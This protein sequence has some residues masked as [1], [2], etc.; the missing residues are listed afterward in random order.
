[1]SSGS[2]SNGHLLQTK[3][4]SDKI[5]TLEGHADMKTFDTMMGLKVSGCSRNLHD[6]EQVR[7]QGLRRSRVLQLSSRL[8]IP[9]PSSPER[10]SKP[11]LTRSPEQRSRLLRKSQTRPQRSLKRCRRLLD[12][13]SDPVLELLSRK[14]ALH[15]LLFLH[16]VAV[17]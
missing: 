14:L 3:R 11:V 13:N 2:T 7:I 9:S 15:S 10:C 1:M 6:Q 17:F 5:D 4:V 12:N 16:V 8:F